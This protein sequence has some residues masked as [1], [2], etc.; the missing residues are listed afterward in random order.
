[1][2]CSIGLQAQGIRIDSPIRFGQQRRDALHHHV[3]YRVQ[4]RFGDRTI[5]LRRR[6]RRPDVDLPTG[7]WHR[8]PPGRGIFPTPH[9]ATGQNRRLSFQEPARPDPSD[10]ASYWAGGADPA[11]PETSVWPDP[12]AKRG[13]RVPQCLP[14][15]SLSV[16]RHRAHRVAVET[17]QPVCSHS[18]FLARKTIW[19]GQGHHQRPRVVVA[20]DGCLPPAEDRTAASP[21][22][23][24]DGQSSRHRPY[25]LARI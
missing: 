14:T 23:P 12:F 25:C 10:P 11:L 19:P 20:T 13:Q 2:R 18:S 17:V 24:G 3:G 7:Q 22:V 6:E 5:N 9:M 21:P 4:Q 15:P 8:H 16:Q 1:M